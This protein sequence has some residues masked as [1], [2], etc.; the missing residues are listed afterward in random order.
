MDESSRNGQFILTGSHQT[1][2][3]SA[4]IQSLAG[5]TTIQR[6][7]PLSL[8]ELNVCGIQLKADEAMLKGGLPRIFAEELDPIRVI[9]LSL[10][11]I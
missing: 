3:H 2:L 11:R 7:L 10:R 5:R 6:L 8:Q 9:T 1:D 4:I